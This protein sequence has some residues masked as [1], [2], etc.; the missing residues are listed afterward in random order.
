MPLV[1]NVSTS[2]PE[3]MVGTLPELDA[4]STTPTT[5]IMMVG[6]STASI[7]TTCAR[8]SCRL[9]RG[10]RTNQLCHVGGLVR[11]GKYCM[12]FRHRIAAHVRGHAVEVPD[13]PDRCQRAQHVVG[14]VDLPPEESLSRRDLIVVV[15]VVPAFP[16]RDDR[17]HG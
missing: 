6:S 8:R 11:S 4:S 10:D 16:H 13:Q 12:V 2:T 17:E 7:S 14:R 1:Q 5:V 15:V 9:A 3:T